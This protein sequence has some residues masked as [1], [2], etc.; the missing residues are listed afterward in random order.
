VE[1]RELQDLVSAIDQDKIQL[2]TSSKGVSWKWNP[3]TAPHFGVVFKSTIK[4]AKQ[5]IFAVLGDAEVN[6]EELETIFIGVESL[7]N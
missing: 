7:L 4:S 6:D 5:A 3:P 1:Q 2:M